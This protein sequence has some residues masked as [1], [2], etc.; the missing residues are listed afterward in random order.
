MPPG[1]SVDF[2]QRSS[3]QLLFFLRKTLGV[4]ILDLI[5]LVQILFIVYSSPYFLIQ[6][7]F[8]F[9]QYESIHVNSYSF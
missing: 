9:L 7:Y 1:F 4:L 8:F 2:Y 3:D 5:T 6:D